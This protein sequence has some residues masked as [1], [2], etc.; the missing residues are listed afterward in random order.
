M[1]KAKV[2]KGR[3]HHVWPFDKTLK[4]GTIVRKEL[5]TQYQG[6]DGK[7]APE[8]IID[9]EDDVQPGWVWNDD[10]QRY[11]P[12]IKRPIPLVRSTTV[13]ILAEKLGI[14]YEELWAEIKA[15]K[16]TKF[17][18]DKAYANTIVSEVTTNI[19]EKLLSGEIMSLSKNIIEAARI[20]VDNVSKEDIKVDDPGVGE[21][22]LRVDK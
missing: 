8:C 11:A 15:R 16:Q 10:L 1:K 20:E 7:S 18:E 21:V 2:S 4:D 3:I 14:D 17:N 13:E 9:V 22:N 19:Q 5:P 6:S 12:I